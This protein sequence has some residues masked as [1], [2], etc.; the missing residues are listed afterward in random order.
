MPGPSS[1]L[2][3]ACVEATLQ[4]SGQA[5]MTCSPPPPVSTRQVVRQFAMRLLELAQA[6][7]AVV[8]RVD[9][10]RD[11]LVGDDAEICVERLAAEPAL[12]DAGIGRCRQQAARR[13]LAEGCLAG[14]G[15]S[16]LPHEQASRPLRAIGQCSGTTPWPRRANASA[17]ADVPLT[18]SPGR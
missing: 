12:D 11:Q 1:G 9:V 13:E 18:A 8:A 16:D 14:A 3:R 15:H 17:W 10:Q 4:P 5:K 2:S 6:F 7:V